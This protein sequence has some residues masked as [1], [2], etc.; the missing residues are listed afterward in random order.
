MA[1]RSYRV[2]A[3]SKRRCAYFLMGCRSVRERWPRY[4]HRSFMWAE[5]PARR[6]GGSTNRKSTTNNSAQP[7]A[8]LSPHSVM[9]GLSPSHLSF[10]R[11]R[12]LWGL[13]QCQL[14]ASAAGGFGPR[15]PKGSQKLDQPLSPI[16]NQ[17]FSLVRSSK[18]APILSGSFSAAASGERILRPR[19]PV[20]DAVRPLRIRGLRADR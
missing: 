7:T 2:K 15:D 11:S 14:R 6:P 9:F 4:F 3:G 1:V 12:S 20:K 19:R 17:R 5:G 8:R 13:K 18:F 16:H 10:K